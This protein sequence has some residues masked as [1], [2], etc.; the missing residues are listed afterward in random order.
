M[1]L[2]LCSITVLYSF[3]IYAD[4]QDDIEIGAKQE[5]KTGNESEEQ[6][7][8]KVSGFWSE[9]IHEARKIYASGNE[10][11]SETD[12]AEESS[13]YRVTS[14]DKANNE[15]E[16]FYSIIDDNY[17]VKYTLA[18][19]E[20]IY[21]RVYEYAVFSGGTTVLEENDLYYPPKL[22]SFGNI[23]R[24]EAS[25]GTN[26]R[27]IQYFNTSTNE[28]SERFLATNAYADNLSLRWTISDVSLF[29]LLDCSENDETVLSVYDIFSKR[30]VERISGS[31]FSY[32]SQ[33]NNILFISDNMVF[34]DHDTYDTNGNWVNR[35][36]IFHFGEKNSKI[37]LI[38]VFELS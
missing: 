1:S 20:G 24:I 16:C 31:F 10:H 5:L 23:I 18:Y 35:K 7:V 19:S 15:Q 38:D 12:Y 3:N 4:Y 8:K 32:I 30:I 14:C 26:H 27:E 11:E 25:Y 2:V 36:E 6:F 29:A 17:H 34:V 21:L 22:E 33:P 13:F 9:S 28:V 37:D